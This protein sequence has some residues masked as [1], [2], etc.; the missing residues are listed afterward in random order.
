[1]NIIEDSKS[2]SHGQSLA[3]VIDKE[4]KYTSQIWKSMELIN[5][6]NHVSKVM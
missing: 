3:G 1:M 5:Y 4:L 2:E 6:L